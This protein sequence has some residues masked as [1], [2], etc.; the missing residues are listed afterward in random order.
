[1]QSDSANCHFLCIKTAQ[2][3]PV[4]YAVDGGVKSIDM[5]QAFKDMPTLIKFFTGHALFCFVFFLAAIIPGIPITFNGEVMESQ[6]LWAKG[7]GL[8]TAVVGLAFPI[9][10]ILILRRWPYCRQ[11]YSVI[12]LSVLVGPYVFWQ[13][14]ASVVFGAVLS[15]A[16]IAYLFLNGQA[17][18][19]FSS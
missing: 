11:L 17:R 15:S 14:L 16:I 19:Y 5:Y 9:A 6:D 4:R 8:P 13:E 7:V 18:A 10:G 2:K 3:P 12:L 1:M